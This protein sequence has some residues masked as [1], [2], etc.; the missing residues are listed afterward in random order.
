MWYRDILLAKSTGNADLSVL[1][2]EKGTIRTLSEKMQNEGIHQCILL[3]H[4]TKR[5]LE[6]N[7]NT[8]ISLEMLVLA[9]KKA[10]QRT[11]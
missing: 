6:Q 2:S 4:E 7:V 3:V 9:Q 5:R 1:S 11:N 10:M 8:E